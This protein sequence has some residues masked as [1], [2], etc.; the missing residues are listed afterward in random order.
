MGTKIIQI[1]TRYKLI[2]LVLCF[3]G[4]LAIGLFFLSN[5][6]KQVQN[7]QNIPINIIDKDELRGQNLM[8]VDESEQPLSLGEGQPQPMK[9]EQFTSVTTTPLTDEE[10]ENILTR[11]PSLPPSIEV[12]SDFKIA[13]GVLP[14]PRTG[15]TIQQPFPPVFE[16]KQ[17]EPAETGSLEVLRFSPEG[18][19]PVAPFISVTFNQP[20]VPL[21]SLSNLNEKEIPVVVQP[22]LPGTWRWLGTKTLTFNYDSNLIDRL[23]KA[24]IYTVTIPEGTRSQTGGVLASEVKWSFT[25]P[26]PKLTNRFP[27]GI[28]QP[29]NP[30]VFLEFDQR[31]V[32]AEVLKFVSMSTGGK[33]I[34]LQ[35]ANEVDIKNNFEVNQLVKAGLD[36]RWMVF[37]AKEN[38]PL[39]SDISVTI[40]PGTPSAEGPLTTTEAQSFQFHTYAP[41]KIEEH[42]CSWGGETCRPLTPL[43]IMFNNPIDP[44]TFKEGMLT[45]SPEIPGVS[46]SIFS[47]RIEIS[48]QTKGRTTYTIT[49]SKEIQ[50]IYGQ[51]LSSNKNLTFKIG[52]ADKL[53]VIPDQTLI[54]LDPA[55]SEASYSVYSINYNKLDVQIFA[56]QPSDWPAFK[57]YLQ[58]YR[59]T[60][61]K[62]V[63]PGKVVLDRAIDIESVPDGLTETSI[64]LKEFLQNQS[65][66]FI[67]IVKPHLNLFEKDQYWRHIQVWL[68]V[69]N[70]GLDAFVDHSN[71]IA[72]TTDLKNG[73][74][75]EGVSINSNGIPANSVTDE[76]G[77][78]T[79]NIPIGATYLTASKGSDTSILPRSSYY[80]GDD[81]WYRTPPTDELRW[82]IFDD[83]QMYKPGEEVH[84]KGWLRRIGGSQTG[85]VGLVGSDVTALTYTITEPQ[86]NEIG[87]GQVDLNSMGGFDFAFTIPMETNLGYSQIT[88]QASGPLT[89]LNNTATSHSFQIQEFRRPVFEVIAR[90]ETPGP[91]FAGEEAIVA[92][93]AKYYAGGALPNAEVVWDV[94]RSNASYNPPN[95]PEFTFGFWTPWWI[96][97]AYDESGI[98]LFDDITGEEV[99]TFTGLTD[100]AGVHYLKI[101]FE[102]NQ[103]ARPISVTAESTV[104]DVNRQAWTSSTNLLVHP[105]NLYVGIRSETYFVEKGTPLRVDL[106]VTDI[107]GKPV[108]DRI[109]DVRAARL[110]WKFKNGR[111]AEEEVDIQNCNPASQL[112]PVQCEFKT[113]IG[114]SYRI[115]A[116]VTDDKN[117]ENKSDITRWV[118]GGKRPPA[119]KVEQEVIT[120][121]PDKDTYQPGDTAR[122]LVQPPFTPAE[123]V[124]TVSRSGILYN[125]TFRVEEGTTTLEIPITEAHI[126]NL[127]I[128]VDVTGSV[129]RVDESGVVVPESPNRPAYASGSINLRIPPL[130]RELEMTAEPAEFELEPGKETLINVNLKDCTGKPVSDADVAVMVVDE[131]ILG[132]TNYI[133]SDP[134]SLFYTDKPTG[135]NTIYSRTSIILSD[136]LAL[137]QNASEEMSAKVAESA[138]RAY[139]EAMPT[140]G[141]PM[142]A[143]MMEAAPAPGEA[144]QPAI[145]IRL[146]FNPL[147]VF[148][149][150]ARTDSSGKVSIQVKLPDNLTRYRVMAVAVDPD[151]KKFGIAESNLTARLPLM[152]RPS[153]PRF[154]NFG[155]EFELPIVLQ[156]QT[157][158]SMEVDIAVRASNLE[159]TGNQ[160]LRVN[161]P[162]RDRIEV[163]FP[164]RT[165]SAG[166][167]HFQAAAVSGIYS[168]AAVIDLPVYTPA[169]TEGFATYGVLDE[170]TLYQPVA[171]PDDVYP[172]FGGLEVHT[173]STALQSLTD[174]VLYL[175]AYPFECSEQLASR[176]LGVA[177][178]RDVLT[179]FEA[180]DLPSPKEMEAAVQRDITRLEGMQN[181]DGGFPYWRRGEDSIPFN[182]I[183][184]AH[185]LQRADMKGFDVPPDMK[186]RSLEYLRQIESYYPNWYGERTKRTLSAYALY[187]RS[188]MGDIDPGKAAALIDNAGMENLSLDTLGWLWK[189]L[190]DSPAHAEKVDSIR[191]LVA[192]RVVETAGAANFTTDY[193]EQNY[194]LLGSDRRTDAILL[195]ALMLDNPDSDLIPK[196][197]NGLM[198]HREKGRWGSTQENVFILLA[199]DKYFNTYEKQ[200]PE[201]VAGIWLGDLYAGSHSFSGRT[202]ERQETSIPMMYL[203]DAVPQGETRDLVISKQG[204]GRLYYRLGMDYSPIDLTLDPLDMGFVVE[205]TYEAVDDP[206]DVRRDSS[207]IWHIK[208]GTKVKVLLTLAA[209]NRRYHVALVDP[210]PAGLEIVNPSLAVTGSQ[211]ETSGTQVPGYGWWW[212]WNW[213]EHQNLRD[214]RAEV[215]TSL[216]WDGVYEYS[217]IARATTPGRFV[218]PPAK[219]EEMYSS[220]V[221][222]RSASDTVIVE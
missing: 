217:Y 195:E 41:L 102:K 108:E 91:Y 82:Y 11:L 151:G 94:T 71:M 35:L 214:E 112:E 135:F 157:D 191:K 80:W 36:S 134:V 61:E 192:N 32:P 174:A 121:I 39:T 12:Q 5:I 193:D 155:D 16:Q 202:T 198:A 22:P 163:R 77:L 8:N 101:N 23:P 97:D 212:H 122:I 178:L 206:A 19:I 31:I 107:D 189:V 131:A 118:S 197:V 123:G 173:S 209:D 126:P 24:T 46:A 143:P 70:I 4:F 213:F 142:A 62:L 50:D 147:A 146:D 175:V 150:S 158:S 74:P 133:L 43:F 56:V 179:A 190:S 180:K 124:L 28:V 83:R 54:T 85:D 109:I 68:Q 87:N 89:N 37:K 149:P 69:T 44:L 201:F 30:L 127:N 200:T 162:A 141:M 66:H 86:G 211:G 148:S 166:E 164:A 194:L 92:V 216:L 2:L 116:V 145:R 9:N 21:T 63:P 73:N 204:P 185:A 132:L 136:P 208:A 210:L 188:L 128:Q 100:S 159:F 114:G 57:K 15:E 52:P 152:V 17:I 25:T 20:M 34:A 10:I 138:D 117:R 26:P 38:L 153:A 65:G 177:A 59:R 49:V 176:V 6:N 110:E 219:A 60:D 103:K 72:W 13:Q 106:I 45:I 113:L 205:R 183:H 222:G 111:W 160:G 93:E 67:L 186:Q 75:M 90:N 3:V 27:E 51:K 48:D 154:L 169:T 218:V 84:I 207:G 144:N 125:E 215:F 33:T 196:V 40:A 29:P 76:H 140:M 167:V 96:F 78:S 64:N 139:G 18:E 119:R 81:A 53:L 1:I 115:S 105:A 130:Q 58:E 79:F 171:A 168:D 203:M 170:G 181:S 220:E 95:W 184:T 14:P 182:T 98:G 129:P 165:I 99:N 221:F 187:V 55:N 156:N 104:M 120:L 88:F 161:V 137:A 47:D 172:Q 42:G 7:V 199:L